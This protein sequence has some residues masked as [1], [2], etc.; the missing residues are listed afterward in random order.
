MDNKIIMNSTKKI[1]FFHRRCKCNNFLISTKNRCIIADYFTH[2]AIS[3]ERCSDNIQ[4][5]II[6]QIF[7]LKIIVF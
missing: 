5:L 4:L 1:R 3:P 6:S 7:Y 2:L